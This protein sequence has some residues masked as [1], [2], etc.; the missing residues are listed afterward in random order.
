MYMISRRL[1]PA[2]S[3]LKIIKNYWRSVSWG[4]LV[5]VGLRRWTSFHLGSTWSSLAAPDWPTLQRSWG[6]VGW[7]I[8]IKQ[9]TLMK[10]REIW[11]LIIG[12]S[13]CV[14]SLVDAIF[15][16]YLK[17]VQACIH[18]GTAP[19]SNIFRQT[20][21]AAWSGHTLKTIGLGHRW[22]HNYA[23]AA[24][25]NRERHD[26]QDHLRPFAAQAVHLR[27][28]FAS[29]AIDYRQR[30]DNNPLRNSG[31]CI[32]SD[33]NVRL[34]YANLLIRPARG[35]CS[36]IG[37]LTCPNQVPCSWKLLEICTK[38]SWIDNDW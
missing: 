3:S 29:S 25:R 15:A 30:E 11:S 36:L 33:I 7:I 19:F 18:E 6:D 2:Q 23:G 32:F 31:C 1:K 27:L 4:N 35:K 13:W 37:V 10:W 17:C 8:G 28:A 9:E 14:L 12:W 22:A 21:E 20:R 34:I 24:P 38:S 26:G 16:T 5:L